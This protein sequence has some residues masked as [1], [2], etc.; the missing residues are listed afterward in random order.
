MEE[1]VLKKAEKYWTR[2]AAGYSKVNQE[3]LNGSQRMKWLRK[4]DGRIRQQYPDENRADIRILDVG[5]GPGFFA[6]ILAEAGYDVTAV[7]YT[8]AMLDQAKANAGALADRIRFLRMDGQDLE[9]PDNTFDVVISRNLTW[10]LEHP[11][12]AYASWKRV[13]EPGGLLLNFDANWYHHLYD[14]QKREAYE[15]DRDAVREQGMEDYNTAP[16]IDEAA[17]EEI[18]RAVPLGKIRRPQWDRKILKELGMGEIKADTEVWKDVW[19][20]AEQVNF[21]ST[22]LFMVAA[23]KE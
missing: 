18:V 9:F 2:R 1:T 4:L 16:D 21:A 23:V 6:V 8:L 20:S 13:L 12:R 7:D 3:E 5:T 11:K 19:S 22:P 14:A 17:M 15:R 10:G